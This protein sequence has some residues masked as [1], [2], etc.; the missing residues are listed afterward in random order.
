VEPG[1]EVEATRPLDLESV[2]SRFPALDRGT[3]FLDNGGGSQIVEPVLDR[4]T[5]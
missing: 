3:V 5:W 4:T 1:E 2:R